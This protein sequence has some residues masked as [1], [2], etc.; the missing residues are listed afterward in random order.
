[1]ESRGERG[2]GVGRGRERGGG[3]GIEK[4]GGGGGGVGGIEK[5]GE[6]VRSESREGKNRVSLV[7]FL[8]RFYTHPRIQK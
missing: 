8:I 2:V 7:H 3:G 4:R 6:R 1:M 5:R